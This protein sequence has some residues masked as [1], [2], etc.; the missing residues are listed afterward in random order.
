MSQREMQ[1]ILGELEKL[2]ASP[3]TWTEDKG[4]QKNMPTEVK[5]RA[6]E[7]HHASGWRILV[8][9]FSLEGQGFPPGSRGWDG[10]AAHLDRGVMTRLTRELATK[11]G[12][13]AERSLSA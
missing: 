13:L 8:V 7:T 1:E 5:A 6:Y 3:I 4:V 9:S 12:E 11:F 10:T 2:L